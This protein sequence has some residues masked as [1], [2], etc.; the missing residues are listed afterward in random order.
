VK[1]SL[2]DRIRTY[3]GLDPSSDVTYISNIVS[4]MEQMTVEQRAQTISA[5]HAFFCMECGSND[6]DCQCWNDE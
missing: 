3:L 4:A 1:P 6:P 2:Q 5:M